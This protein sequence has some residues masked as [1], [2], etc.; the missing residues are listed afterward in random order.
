[1]TTPPDDEHSSPGGPNA[2]SPP[3]N[4]AAPDSPSAPALGGGGAPSRVTPPRVTPSRAAPPTPDALARLL[5]RRSSTDGAH[6]DAI[7]RA[8]VDASPLAMWVL[9]PDAH[10]L[11]WK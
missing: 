6:T 9:D 7:L 11:L 1:M 8:L 5:D 4:S 2:P 3:G 10:V